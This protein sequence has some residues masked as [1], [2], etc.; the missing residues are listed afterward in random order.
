MF[1]AGFTTIGEGKIGSKEVPKTALEEAADLERMRAAQEGQLD[2]IKSRVQASE[3]GQRT[4]NPMTGEPITFGSSFPK[5]FQNKGY[6][7]KEVLNVMN[8]AQNWEKLTNRQQDILDDLIAASRGEFDAAMRMADPN[9]QSEE[10]RNLGQS[11]KIKRPPFE[12]SRS[13]FME[14]E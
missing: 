10:L 4:V 14:S 8:K 3:A 9:I 7:K 2:F 12:T 13:E 5:W 6:T 1:G 11:K